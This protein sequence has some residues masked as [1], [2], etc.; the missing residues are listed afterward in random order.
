MVPSLA[1]RA[2]PFDQKAP[3]LKL[4]CGAV[5]S[6]LGWSGTL[7]YTLQICPL[8]GEGC[9]EKRPFSLQPQF[10]RV[11][12]NRHCHFFDRPVKYIIE[13]NSDYNGGRDYVAQELV[14]IGFDWRGLYPD[15]WCLE[16]G[17]A[18]FTNIDGKL[19]LR[20]GYFQRVIRQSCGWSALVDDTLPPPNSDLPPELV[21]A[22][23]P[24]RKECPGFFDDA[25][26]TGDLLWIQPHGID[27]ADGSC[28]LTGLFPLTPKLPVDTLCATKKGY[29][30]TRFTFDRIKGKTM[31]L[32]EGG[33]RRVTYKRCEENWYVDPEQK[34]AA[35]KLKGQTLSFILDIDS[36]L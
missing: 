2:Q 10:D 14:P 29:K 34:K 17:T 5:T 7:P 1:A 4:Y 12:S 24:E 25:A 15:V 30:R 27:R 3:P 20:A 23:V 18:H 33:K 31:R 13:Y 32:R 26:R 36:E 22:W 6:E 8:N 19:A 21:G 9:G 11:D 28:W 16:D 35:S